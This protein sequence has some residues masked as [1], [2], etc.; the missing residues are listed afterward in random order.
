MKK[1]F[2]KPSSKFLM[3]L[4]AIL[5][6]L[7]SLIYT[8]KLVKKISSEERKKIELWAQ[9]YKEIQQVDLNQEISLVVFN[10]IYEN[11][12]IPVIL[13]DNENNIIGYAN[14]DTAKVDDEVYLQEQL[15]IM[16][17]QHE[18]I[19][20]DYYQGQQNFIYYKDSF[21]LTQLFYYPFIQFAVI[22]LFVVVSFFA[23]RNAQK[24]EENQLWVGMSKETAHQLGTP[25]SSLIAWVEILK[26]KDEDASLVSEVEKDVQRLETITERFSKI[27]STPN[28][29]P[30]NIIE[31]L[32][33]SIS[34][35]K[36]R[37]S[38]KIIYNLNFDENQE[39][40]IPINIALIEWVVENLCKNAIDAM[41][42]KG[43]ISISIENSNQNFIIDIHD[44]G[45]GIP[46]RNFKTVFRPGYTTKKRGWG[47]GL[48]LAKR[49]IEIYHKGKIYV[50][51]SEIGHGTTFRIILKK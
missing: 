28:L 6:G 27:G 21:L 24:A 5:I 11:K 3:F 48:S 39:V 32:K 18:P 45:K 9:A 38:T 34:Y 1:I 36:L 20:I 13:L 22:I 17:S 46:K 16:K 33:N 49:I 2:V 42:E 10:M 35:L 47:L 30:T 4:I 12:T 23:F 29:I 31:I 43:Q 51:N 26:M 19:I 44:T 25:I 14:L 7:A 50:K 15:K 41:S 8:N 37:T 40:I